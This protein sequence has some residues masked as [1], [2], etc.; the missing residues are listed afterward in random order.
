ME[1]K[2]DFLRFSWKPSPQERGDFTVLGAFQRVFPEFW[3]PQLCGDDNQ[4]VNT[5]SNYQRYNFCRNLGTDCLIFYDEQVLRNKGVNVSIPSHGLWLIKSVFGY[6]NFIDFLRLIVE[7]RNCT[8][9]RIDLAF[10]DYKYMEEG[11]YHTAK[12]FS[13][14]NCKGALISSSRFKNG[15]KPSDECINVSVGDKI[16]CADCSQMIENVS[17][18]TFYLGSRRSPRYMRIYDKFK[19]SK[20]DHDVWERNHK[21][22]DNRPEPEIIDAVR[23]EFE[24]KYDFADSLV[25]ALLSGAKYTFSD[26]VSEWFRIVDLNKIDVLV[27][28]SKYK[29]HFDKQWQNFL[30]LEFSEDINEKPPLFIKEK[31]QITVERTMAWLEQYVMPSLALMYLVNGHSMSDLRRDIISYLRDFGLPPDKQVALYDFTGKD[32]AAVMRDFCF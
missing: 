8:V 11:H 13:D 14:L 19:K 31:K 30:S 26:F 15:I 17:G 29:I 4:R 5:Y 10:D 22:K 16:Y 28:S 18:N 6:D 2:L 3:D 7:E 1:M 21:G 23:Y 24:I 9:S 12:E 27:E 25:R 20:H 32:Y